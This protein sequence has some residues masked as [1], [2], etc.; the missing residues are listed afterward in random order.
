[1]E[2]KVLT[3]AIDK[4]RV[5]RGPRKGQLLAKCPPVNTPGAAAWQA[6]MS[7]ANPYKVGFGHMMFMEKENREIYNKIRT[8]ILARKI[9]VNNL[10]RDR[11]ALE[12]L[13]VW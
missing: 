10:D 7:H 13:G 3:N 11:E 4:A 8:F 6:I 2:I 12:A 1:M 9:N 5:T